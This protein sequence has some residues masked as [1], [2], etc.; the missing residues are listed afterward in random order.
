MLGR[1]LVNK[2][3]AAAVRG[4]LWGY[5]LGYVFCLACFV[6]AA[7]H[8]VFTLRELGQAW[9]GGLA[10]FYEPGADLFSDRGRYSRWVRGLPGPGSGRNV[11]VVE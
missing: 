3:A 11:V 9:P 6:F 7:R 2:Y 1:W 10:H 5:F 8:G 4:F